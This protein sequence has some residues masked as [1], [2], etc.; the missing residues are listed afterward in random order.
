MTYSVIM[1]LNSAG[2]RKVGKVISLLEDKGFE[3]VKYKKKTTNPF[4]REY[5]DIGQFLF[6]NQFEGMKAMVFYNKKFSPH[7]LGIKMGD[8]RRNHVELTFD[9]EVSV[10]PNELWESIFKNV[11]GNRRKLPI[12]FVIKEGDGDIIV[13]DVILESIEASI[14]TRKTDFTLV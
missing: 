6:Q 5:S 2:H 14:P 9:G 4:C 1:A 3:L 7:V 10:D 13:D 11:F 12:M 8:F